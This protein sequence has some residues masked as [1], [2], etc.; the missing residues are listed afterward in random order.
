MARDIPYAKIGINYNAAENYKNSFNKDYF[1]DLFRLYDA[2]G[3]ARSEG[4]MKIL[5]N[6]TPAK[7][8]EAMIISPDPPSNSHQ[9][10]EVIYKVLRCYI[11]VLGMESFNL[12]IQ[13]PKISDTHSPFLI[14]IVDRGRIFSKTVD[15]GG[16]ELYGSIVVSDDPYHLIGV[17]N[18]HWDKI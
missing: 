8:K 11:D 9:A 5:L 4:N 18:K 14:K 16:M 1:S 7:D 17:L 13:C 12:A 15:M 6:I 2:L 10:K 3:L